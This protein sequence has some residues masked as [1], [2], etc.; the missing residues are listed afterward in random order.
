MGHIA[1]TPDW[2]VNPCGP[3]RFRSLQQGADQAPDDAPKRRRITITV[4]PGR[5]IR[6]RRRA[7]AT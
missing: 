6:P 4:A 1:S 3:T 7:V 5:H 2:V